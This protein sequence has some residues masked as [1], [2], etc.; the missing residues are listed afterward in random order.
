MCHLPTIYWPEFLFIAQD[1]Q[2]LP[3][4]PLVLSLEGVASVDSP[5]AVAGLQLLL[6]QD[7]AGGKAT[8]MPLSWP[9]PVQGSCELCLDLVT[10]SQ[11]PSRQHRAK[12]GFSA[13]LDNPLSPSLQATSQQSIH[14]NM[15]CAPC[16]ALGFLSFP[17]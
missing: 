7:E 16:P 1:K 17:R 2:V 13:L 15:C 5:R 10:S 6:L 8:L 4:F 9:L 3:S 12:A 14:L 11:C